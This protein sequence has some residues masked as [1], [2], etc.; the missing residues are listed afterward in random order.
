MK[1]LIIQSVI[2]NFIITGIFLIIITIISDVK[3]DLP[4]EYQ[5]ITKNDTL[6]GYY[7]NG[8]LHIEFNNK[9]NNF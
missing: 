2:V 5:S 3:I 8:I 7:E 4:E 6:K 1:K 9:K